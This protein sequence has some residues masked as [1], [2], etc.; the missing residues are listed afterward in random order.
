METDKQGYTVKNH[1]GVI[2]LQWP[3]GIKNKTA[4]S[5]LQKFFLI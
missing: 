1:Q 3:M 5:K 2:G 4:G